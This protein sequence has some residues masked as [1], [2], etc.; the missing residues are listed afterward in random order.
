[1]LLAGR[2]KERV[3]HKTGWRLY[4]MMMNDYTVCSVTSHASG[5]RL[6]IFSVFRDLGNKLLYVRDIS[7]SEYSAYEYIMLSTRKAPQRVNLAMKTDNQT[8]HT[9]DLTQALLSFATFLHQ[10]HRVSHPRSRNRQAISSRIA[11]LLTLHC[12][13]AGFEPCLSLKSPGRPPSSPGK[14]LPTLF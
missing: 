3:L 5:P 9:S 13:A 4:T 6:L 7:V 11:S 14:N 10:F 8:K 12:F 2:A 1:M